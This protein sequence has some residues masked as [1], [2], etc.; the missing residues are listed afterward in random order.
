MAVKKTPQVATIQSLDRG[1]AILQAVASSREPMS[2]NDVANLIGIDRS[3]AFRLL[4]TL[5][6]RG[7]LANPAARKDYILGSTVWTL[8]NHYDWSQMLVRIASGHLKMLAAETNETAHIAIREGRSALFIDYAVA[9]H[10]IAVAGRIG[11]LLPLYCTAHGKALLA[12]ATAAELKSIFSGH[13]LR[14]YTPSTIT[15]LADLARDCSLIAERGYAVDD[16]E[17]GEEIRCVA[18]PIRAQGGDIVGSIGISA[19]VARVTPRSLQ[20]SADYVVRIAGEIGDLL[21]AARKEA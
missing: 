6:Q 1:L 14:R 20:A 5:R 13:P 8:S 3:T 4:H 7:F 18:A 17:F 15:T 11:Q 2:L 9:S 19:P 12:D 10:M 16:A 21:S